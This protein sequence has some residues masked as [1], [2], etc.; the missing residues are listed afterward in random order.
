MLVGATLANACGYFYH[1]LMGRMLGPEGYGILA[2]LISLLYLLSIASNTLE[3]VV[4]RFAAAAAAR[5]DYKTIIILLI[6]F[7]RKFL[8][9]GLICT[10]IFTALN[11]TISH[12]LDLDGSR[13]ALFV[14]GLSLLS[15]FLL[16]INNGVLRGLQNFRFL[17]ANSV[18]LLAVR[19]IVS[20]VLVKS[21]FSV[22]GAVIG[23]VLADLLAYFISLLPLK[24]LWHYH[25][26]QAEYSV[27]NRHLFVLPALIT[28][29]GLTSL[30]SSDIVLAKHFFDPHQAGLYAALAT[31][32]KIVV[33]ASAVVPT[34]LLPIAT[35][36]HETGQPCRPVLLRALLLV[37]L[38]SACLSI[39]FF[40]A[41][42]LMVKLLYGS[43]Y[44]D[45]APYLG[46]FAV[47]ISF[48]SLVNV[49][50][51][52]FISIKRQLPSY[53]VLAGASLQVILITIFHQSIPQIILV[54]ITTTALLLLGLLLYYFQSDQEQ[55]ERPLPLCG[56]PRL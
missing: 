9:V 6:N 11:N 35:E 38:S 37:G 49:L 8:L 48:Y 55:T 19:I 20:V 47:F 5:K 43:L 24:F 3:T 34:V 27:N 45:I 12:F 14:L 7:S 31:L 39:F 21:G 26:K 54:S 41:S 18:L 4:A 10:L 44:V 52:Y 32:G 29:L 56:D 28:T 23:I 16:P 33:F 36:K 30:Y 50:A 42:E 15:K 51:S 22:L 13:M 40:L 17:S 2:A 46:L 1:L 53:L 25:Q